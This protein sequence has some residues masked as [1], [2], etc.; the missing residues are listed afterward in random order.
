[1]LTSKTC[2]IAIATCVL[3]A[4]LAALADPP[5]APPPAAYAACAAKQAGDRCAVQFGDRSVEGACASGPDQQLFCRPD[6]PPHHHGPPPE[7]VAACA[8]LKAG[9][10][11]SV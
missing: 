11:C 2:S 6:R 10:V 4:A 3:C 5:H 8:S 9:D 1:M 7:A